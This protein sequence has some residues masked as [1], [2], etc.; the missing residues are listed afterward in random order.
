MKILYFNTNI[1]ISASPFSLIQM[2]SVR[3]FVARAC[4]LIWR[5]TKD[6]LRILNIS[7]S[8]IIKETDED[9]IERL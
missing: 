4:Y 7:V 9:H 6:T 2:R 1:L 8:S 5:I 3:A